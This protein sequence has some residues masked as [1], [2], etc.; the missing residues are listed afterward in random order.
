MLAKHKPLN[1]KPYTRPALAKH[2]QVL[3]TVRKSDDSLRIV[4]TDDM[5]WVGH[6]VWIPPCL[7]NPKP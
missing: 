6:V 3:M 4:F 7:L 5:Q 2:N 1:P